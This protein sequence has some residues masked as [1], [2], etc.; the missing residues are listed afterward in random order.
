MAVSTLSPANQ[1]PGR[2]EASHVR[3]GQTNR[4]GPICEPTVLLSC[5][6]GRASAV[7]RPLDPWGEPWVADLGQHHALDDPPAAMM[8]GRWS[9]SV[10]KD[11]SSPPAALF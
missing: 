4:S 1:P 2:P 7:D 9:R 5:A 10:D 11:I 8:D 3:S 6:S